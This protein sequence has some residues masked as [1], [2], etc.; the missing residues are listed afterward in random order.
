MKKL[1][2]KEFS[3]II[4]SED[5]IIFPQQIF[6]FFITKK[7]KINI[8]ELNYEK[9]L[10][11]DKFKNAWV[12]V[13]KIM[14]QNNEK[15]ELTYKQYLWTKNWMNK[16]LEIT[17]DISHFS[18]DVFL[19]NQI[20]N[21]NLTKKLKKLLLEMHNLCIMQPWITIE[22]ARNLYY[23]ACENCIL[24]VADEKIGYFLWEKTCREKMLEI[25]IIS[26][27]Y[28]SEKIK[29]FVNYFADGYKLVIPSEWKSERGKKLL[30]ESLKKSDI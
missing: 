28:D 14:D 2:E 22:N 1:I 6:G 8:L 10:E 23:Y 24:E 29:K 7:K 27:L 3:F 9:T 17:E 4:N 18:W 5:E 12:R 19:F 21:L 11:N 20:D 15:I 16:F 30:L 26:D 13:R 25:E